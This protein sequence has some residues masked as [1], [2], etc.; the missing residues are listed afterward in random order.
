MHTF[1]YIQ[2]VTKIFF[3]YIYKEL[4]DVLAETDR[5]I[6]NVQDLFGDDVQV[7]FLE[8]FF[9]FFLEII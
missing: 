4:R 7:I 8:F 5:T 9:F 2:I 6:A 1:N 3:F